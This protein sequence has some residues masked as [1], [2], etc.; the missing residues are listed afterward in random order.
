M[1]RCIWLVF[2]IP[3]FAAAPAL[4][5]E[6]YAAINSTTKSCHV[7]L[8]KPDEDVMR[9]L[10]GPYASYDEALTAVNQ[11]RECGGKGS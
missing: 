2:L 3:A 10:G 7:V 4:A 5:T 1:R 11:R 9:S 6:F 8:V